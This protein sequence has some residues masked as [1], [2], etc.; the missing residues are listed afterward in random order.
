[1]FLAGSSWKR[2][3]EIIV[4]YINK[5]PARMKWIFAPHE[6]NKS[7]IERLE[8]LLEVSY[9]RFSQFNSFSTDARV[10]IID[11]IGMLSSAYR[12][13]YIAAIGGG[14]GSGIHNVLEPVCWGIPV[15]FGPNHTKFREA[16]DLIAAKGAFTF[17]NYD[18]FEQILDKL[19]EDKTMYQKASQTVTGYIH[20]NTGA[21]EKIVAMVLGDA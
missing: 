4:R 1:V 12:Y 14:F 21:T 19:I 13:A 5:Y 6:V 2:D 16:E 8:R 9:I 11:N 15:L 17:K 10:L 20:V 7:N 18:E 3:E